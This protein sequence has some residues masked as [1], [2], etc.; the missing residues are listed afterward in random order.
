MLKNQFEFSLIFG[1]TLVLF[2]QV[3]YLISIKNYGI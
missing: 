1:K 3:E 2:G